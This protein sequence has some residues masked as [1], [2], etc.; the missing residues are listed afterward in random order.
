VTAIHHHNHP[1]LLPLGGSSSGKAL[2]FLLYPICYFVPMPTTAYSVSCIFNHLV[3]PS[4][5]LSAKWWFVHK[6]SL[7]MLSEK[8]YYCLCIIHIHTIVTFIS[9]TT[10]LR[11]FLLQMLPNVFSSDFKLSCSFLHTA[12]P[13][14]HWYPNTTLHGVTSQKTS[15]RIFATV[16][17]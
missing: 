13:L 5:L 17:T 2:P 1:I 14:E 15:T 11:V 6:S 12:W 16:K 4:S 10:F 9:S 3:S 8:S 7:L